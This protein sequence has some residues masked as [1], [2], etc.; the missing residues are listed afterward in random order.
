VDPLIGR[1]EHSLDSKGRLVLPARLR[2][3]FEAIGGYLT[4]GPEGCVDL[5]PHDRFLQKLA[6]LEDQADDR[7][8]RNMLRVFAA[9]EHVTPDSQGRILVA[10]YLMDFAGLDPARVLVRGAIKTVQLWNPER[11]EQL[12]AQAEELLLNDQIDQQEAS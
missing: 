3:P 2:P 5:W 9:T 10:P 7:R 8:S 12:E 6:E 1:F 4:K 11:W